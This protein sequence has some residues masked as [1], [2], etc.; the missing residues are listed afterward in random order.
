MNE[1]KSISGKK[2]FKIKVIIQYNDKIKIIIKYET[3]IF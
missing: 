3:C 1:K 2:I